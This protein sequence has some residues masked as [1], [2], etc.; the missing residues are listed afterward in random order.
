MTLP[1][2]NP[3]ALGF[4]LAQSPF[5]GGFGFSRDGSVSARSFGPTMVLTNTPIVITATFTTGG[6]NALGGFYYGH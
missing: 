2:N 3:V 4:A 1:I 6:S 5:F